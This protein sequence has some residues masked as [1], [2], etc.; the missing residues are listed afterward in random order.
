MPHAALRSV[1]RSS[2]LSYDR[3]AQR[4]LVEASS[5]AVD[6]HVPDVPDVAGS[7]VAA[8]GSGAGAGAG[9]DVK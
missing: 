4:R 5:R 3:D 1:A 6:L 2:A 7:G 8:A 9:E